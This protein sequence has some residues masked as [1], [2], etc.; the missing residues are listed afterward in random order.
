MREDIEFIQVAVQTLRS[1]MLFNN[2]LHFGSRCI[3]QRLFLELKGPGTSPLP[4][5]EQI[6]NV[7][8]NFAYLREEAFMTRSTDISI[9]VDNKR[10]RH[11][12]R[13]KTTTRI[14]RISSTVKCCTGP[15]LANGSK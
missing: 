2:A 4:D 1:T 9:T 8:N 5:V 7:R 14:S 12:K 13:R 11:G 10:S 6:M 3:T 15:Y